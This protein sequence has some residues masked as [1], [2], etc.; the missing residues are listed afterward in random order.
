MPADRVCARCGATRHTQAG[1]C[2]RCGY[3]DSAGGDGPDESV[4]SGGASPSR[5][6]NCGVEHDWR[7]P[8]CGNCGRRVY[9][10]CLT[11]GASNGTGNRHCVYCGAG[12]R[13]AGPR[14]ISGIL[15]LGA[16]P[17]RLTA[18]GIARDWVPRAYWPYLPACGLLAIVLAQLIFNL[19]DV[20]GLPASG[21]FA[22]LVGIGTIAVWALLVGEPALPKEQGNIRAWSESSRQPREQSRPGWRLAWLVG[23]IVLLL[24]LLVR[25]LGGQG[26]AWDIPL[27]FGTM[28]AFAAMFLPNRWLPD[29]RA[30]MSAVSARLVDA[31]KRHWRKV[32]P[33]LAIIVVYCALTVPNL[34]AWRYAALGDEYLFYEH[35]RSTLEMGSAEPFSQNGVYNNNPEFNTIYKSVWMRV[36]GDDHL[37]WKAT[38]VVSMIMALSGMYVLGWLLGGRAVAVA[39]VAFLASSHYLMGLLHGGYNHLDALPVTLWGLALFVLG[40]RRK[41]ALFL[42]LAGVAVGLG[43]YFHYSARIMGPVMLGAAMLSVHPRD[44]RRLWPMVPGFLLAAWPTLWLAQEEILT[45][46]FAQTVGGYSDVVAGPAG[47]RLTSNLKLNLPSFFFNEASHTYVSGP[48]LDPITGALAA[49]GIGLAVGSAGRLAANLCLVWLAVGFVATGLISPYPTTAITRLFPLVPPLALLAGMAAANLPALAQGWRPRVPA[50]AAKIAAPSLLVV[51]LAAVFWFNTDRAISGTHKVFHYT[52]ESLAIGAS[53][54]EHCGSQPEQTLFVGDAPDST[55]AKAI[56]SYDPDAPGHNVLSYDQF[57]LAG[58]RPN[59]VCVVF[60]NPDTREARRAMVQLQ[61]RYPAGTFYTF[62][63]PSR[64]NSVEFFRLPQG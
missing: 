1:V 7:T 41:N 59:T 64:K 58:L 62:T 28:G 61:D 52:P 19:A 8:E 53:R 26:A 45:K 42:F 14:G 24:F 12:V 18:R 36:F 17:S 23:G 20:R 57:D 11:C 50:R 39:S 34:T 30:G 21:A 48:L 3:Y 44:Y 43:F 22:L 49:A 27:W 31:G 40:M 37:G 4:P 51:L 6:P 10:Q 46:M 38:G 16:S 25:V 29:F 60:H 54:S 55:L 32:I 13:G 9:R 63:T 5:C 15:P 47:E 56:S 35:A 33:L 2:P